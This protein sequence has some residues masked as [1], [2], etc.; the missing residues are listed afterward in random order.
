MDN[1]GRIGLRTRRVDRAAAETPWVELVGSDSGAGMDETTR[2]RIFEPFFTTKGDGTGLGLATVYGIV[3]QRGGEIDVASQL[4]VG[5]TF[6][7]RFPA[8]ST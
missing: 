6:S 8:L 3:T 1:G 7:V 5:T 2:Q 4:G